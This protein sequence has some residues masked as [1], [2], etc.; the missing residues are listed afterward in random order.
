M[1]DQMPRA[2]YSAHELDFISH[3]P[4]QTERI[5]QR[6]GALLC[7]GDLLCLLG[8]FGVGKTQLVRGIARGLNSPDAVTSPSFVFVNEYRAHTDTDRFTLSHVDLYRIADSAEL[9]T[10]GLDELWEGDGVCV[11]EWPERAAEHL[12]AHHLAIQIAHLSETKRR[13]R[14]VPHGERYTTLLT[15]FKE[16]AFS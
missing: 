10:I 5:G 8:T 11:I 12:P 3:S 9:S 2:V 6:L 13:L 14:F 1:S 15:Q 16:T 4:T 7:P